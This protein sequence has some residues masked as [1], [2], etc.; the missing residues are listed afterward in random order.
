MRIPL[1]KS[2]GGFGA[3]LAVGLAATAACLAAWGAGLLDRAELWTLDARM[4][5]QPTIQSSD[6][7]LHVDIDDQAI[8][9]I[10][11]WPWPRRRIAQLIRTLDQCGAKAVALDILFPAPQEP[12][13]IQPGLTDLAHRPGAELLELPPEP[14]LDDLELAEA[15]ADCPTLF[16]AMHA[17][18]GP[19]GVPGSGEIASVVA[20][21]LH[22][23]PMLSLP[24]V[25][26]ELDAADGAVRE[27]ARQEYL[28]CR[29]LRAIA[30]SC[31]P[32]L[33]VRMDA[34]AGQAAPPLVSFAQAAHHFGLVS[35][36]PDEDGK[37][38]RL[39]LLSRTQAGVLPQLG[40]AL[41]AQFLG[42]QA[43]RQCR[44]LA[45]QD[46]IDLVCGQCRLHVPTDAHGWLRVNWPSPRLNDA[47]RHISALAAADVWAA[48][49]GLDNN[50]ELRRLACAELARLLGEKAVVELSG[51]AALA[52]RD[53]QRAC[54]QYY[55]AVLYEP[56]QA[57]G[58]P[59]QERL[60]PAHQ[61]LLEARRKLDEACGKLIADVDSFYLA[62]QDSS[63]PAAAPATR[64]SS[65]SPDSAAV[66]PSTGPDE[67][68]PP[69]DAQLQKAR[70][71]R[72]I[73]ASIDQANAALV[74][75]A[76]DAARR[77]AARVQGR[78]CLVGQ[79]STGAAD[80][81]ATPVDGPANPRSPGVLVHSA[82]AETILSG[83]FVRELSPWLAASLLVL[84]GLLAAAVSA[85]LGP[86]MAA[87]SLALLAGAYVFFGLGAWTRWVLALPL[88][89]P[90][91][92]MAVV[93]SAVTAYR[94]LVEQRRRRQVTGIFKR[95]L[96]PAMVDEL[97][98]DPAQAALS[99]Q[100]RE[101][102]CLF[103]DL[104]GFT[105]IS[106]A[107]GPEGTVRLL[108]RY[109][110]A[111]GEILQVSC[112][113]TL[114]KYEGDGIFAFFGA[115]I[116]Q[117]D[118]AARALRAAMQC[119]AAM[120][121]FV[122]ACRQEGLLREGM[123]MSARFGIASGQ[124]FVGNMGSSRRVAYTAIGD[125]VNL[126]SRLESACRFFGT[127]VLVDE[128]AWLAGGEGL[129]ARPLGAVQ[130]AGRQAPVKVYEPVSAAGQA[131]AEQVEHLERFARARELLEAGQFAR[132]RQAFAAIPPLHTKDH[133][134]GVFAEICAQLA[135][136]GSEWEGYVRLTEK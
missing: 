116:S 81:V 109:L 21:E 65:Q 87:G 12:R 28:T 122:H 7:I 48:Q 40:L 110:D 88:V 125:V 103:A 89:G 133:L 77:L 121:A 55:H 83:Q 75:Q 23:R 131:T 25:L 37:L 132:A 130:V 15:I 31:L 129:L 128:R 17:Q 76:L 45:G 92:T 135:Q 111:M 84:A 54:R 8:D 69:Q 18:L 97:V 57:E 123:E 24:Q 33:D 118:H 49:E 53:F 16:L 34:P 72:A 62:G 93:F 52:R 22:D 42:Q 61:A 14:V 114:S 41:A 66:K 36:Q 9:Q 47:G 134:A 51:Q 126:A 27:R 3:A 104:A 117:S 136:E 112:G 98:A 63:A 70:E 86:V 101:L 29:A 90:A 94:Q 80:M 96:S 43:G 71:L 56:D 79:M 68:T 13:F 30:P 1:G 38:R 78:I 107:L 95:Y 5:R 60:W 59:E 64:P 113:G 50:D 85:R 100:R 32:E 4:R 120:P 106:E 67:E 58:W 73:V 35:I 82:V 99:G 74:E 127:G 102:S 39:P 124:V 10:G 46:G 108:N 2:G 91:A 11:R 20:R 26:E 115:P 19:R 119:Q 6:Q 105:G 44:I